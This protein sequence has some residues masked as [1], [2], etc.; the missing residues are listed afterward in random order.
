MAEFDYKEV[1]KATDNFN[2]TRMIGKG[3]HGMVYKGM[4]LKHNRLVAIK[5]RSEGL[6]SV[7][8]NSKLENE[9]RVLSCLSESPYVVKFVGKSGNYYD[10]DNDNDDNKVI[11]MEL[12]PNGSLYH[13]LHHAKTPLTWHKRIEISM[14]IARAL[15]FLHERN[16][17]VI[18]RDIKSSNILF[19]SEFNAKLADFGLAVTGVDPPSQPAGTIGYLDP[20]YI[21]PCKLSTKNDMFSFGVVLLEII[22]G[23]KAIDVCN[24]PSSIVEWA[25]PLI[26]RQNFEEICDSRMPLPPHMVGTVNY[27]L[28]YAAACVS[29]NQHDRPSAR[30]IVASMENCFVER[31]RFPVWRSVFRCMVRFGKKRT[32]VLRIATQTHTPASAI[33]IKDILKLE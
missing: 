27:L 28:R 23:R 14:Q 20:C 31:V 12:M 30:E 9:I 11:V 26:Q 3:S 7:N 16:P 24:T 4:L 15:Q 33:T 22:S 29:Q 2:I 17:L 6:E 1:V 10:N 18:H 19:D 32:L 21:T 25:I 13:W 5:K 8:D